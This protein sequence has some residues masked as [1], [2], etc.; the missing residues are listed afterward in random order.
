MGE[1]HC[2]TAAAI[3]VHRTGLR[4][5]NFHRIQEAAIFYP[6]FYPK[7]APRSREVIS[8]GHSGQLEWLA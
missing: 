2:R 8:P 1:R 4:R 7:A 6:I 3:R 5:T